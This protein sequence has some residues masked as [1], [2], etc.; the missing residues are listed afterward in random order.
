MSFQSTIIV[1]NINPV[2]PI[3]PVVA[4]DYKGEFVNWT[5]GDEVKREFIKNKLN[6]YRPNSTA[7]VIGN[8]PGNTNDLLKKIILS[9]NRKIINYYNTIY[10]CNIGYKD[11]TPDF[12]VLTN[13][14]LLNKI[15]RD[16]CSITYTRP[17]IYRLNTDFNLIPINYTLD[18]GSTAAM[19]AAYHGATKVFLIGFDGCPGGVTNH[20]Y[21]NEQF[22][23]KANDEVNDEKW[24]INLGRV[25]AAYPNTTF[26]RVNASPPSSRHLQKLSNYQIV[27]LRKFISL[28]DL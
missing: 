8:G 9:N 25:I 5:I 15:P 21:V 23:P 18:A 26:Y 4:P 7:I 20:K 12:L 28:A 22:Y 24:Q 19:L 6:Y 11:I 14:L 27:D 17:E 3:T 2:D 13:K 10:A 16:L 1:K